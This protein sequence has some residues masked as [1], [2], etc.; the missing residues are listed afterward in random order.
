MMFGLFK[1]RCPLDTREKAWTETRMRWLADKFGIDRLRRADVILPTRE[2]FPDDYSGEERQVRPLFDRVCRY[3]G[4]NP[5]GLKLY[6]VP[7]N[8]MVD[9][10]GLYFREPHTVIYVAQRL[11]ANQQWLVATLTHEVAH[12]L[13]LGEGRLG[14]DVPDHEWITDLLPV[15]LGMGIFAANSTLEQGSWGFRC[16]GYLPSHVF[17]YAM[18]LFLFA[19]GEGRPAWAEHLRPDAK[20]ALTKGLKYLQKTGDSLFH[21]DTLAAPLPLPTTPSAACELLSRSP[22]WQ[23]V[24][25]EELHDRPLLERKVLD[26]VVKC[27][28]ANDPEIAAAANE[29]M[30]AMGPAAL[31]AIDVAVRAMHSSDSHVCTTGITAFTAM[32]QPQP[33]VLFVLNDL[34]KSEDPVVASCARRAVGAYGPRA[35]RVIPTLMKLLKRAL[36]KGLET[37]PVELCRLLSQVSPDYHRL[38]Q[39]RFQHDDELIVSVTD[40]LAAMSEADS[41]VLLAADPENDPDAMGDSPTPSA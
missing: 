37:E 36:Y 41:Q 22:T 32:K 9:T 15:F 6:I 30:A 5:A 14:T 25:L 28:Q 8:Q 16:Q 38:I 40:A 2:F 17:G 33:A 13:L 18:A 19:R 10:G 4:V 34:M 31:P 29:A 24:T 39:E 3:M 11:L 21:P 1:T 27:A 7:D 20:D 23:L 35:A 12:E 26:A